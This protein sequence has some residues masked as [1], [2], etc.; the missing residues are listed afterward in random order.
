[1]TDLRDKILD[2]TI[3]VYAENGYRGTTTRRIASEAGV[4]EVTLFRHFGS[5]DELIKAALRR[6]HRRIMGEAPDAVHVDPAV[7]IEQWAIGLHQRFHAHNRVIRQL[8]GDAQQR[9]DLVMEPGDD[10]E[11]EVKAIIVWF[12][13]LKA[14][15]RLADDADT[16]IAGHMLVNT[17]FTDALWR[18]HTPPGVVPPAEEVIRRLV[19]FTLRAL[20][21][22]TADVAGGREVA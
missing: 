10:C 2:V 9:P 21:Y 12:D 16:L 3:S 8:L 4:N 18:D 7:A 22:S 5:K 15:G 6:E 13:A 14:Q 20:G 1:M 19:A 17:L 11:H